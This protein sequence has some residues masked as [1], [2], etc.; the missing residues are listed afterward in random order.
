MSEWSFAFL[1]MWAKLKKK[2]RPRQRCVINVLMGLVV[3]LSALLAANEPVLCVDADTA[4]ADDIV[5][6]VR[7]RMAERPVRVMRCDPSEEPPTWRV[8]ARPTGDDVL[9]LA[10]DGAVTWSQDLDV[11]AMRAAES[12]RLVALHVVEAVRESVSALAVPVEPAAPVAET[13]V[14]PP[15]VLALELQV[16]PVLGADPFAVIGQV[17]LAGKWQREDTSFLG[18]VAARTMD[19]GRRL[20]VAASGFELHLEFA[21]RKRFWQHTDLGL[22][23]RGRAARVTISGSN[24][25]VRNGVRTY[26]DYGAGASALQWLWR[27][28]R[29]AV[30]LVVQATG[31]LRPHWLSVEGQELLRQPRID[32]FLGPVLELQL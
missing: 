17:Q 30:G 25:D 27:G 19:G 18:T 10:I 26:F 28:E 1:P 31:W 20:D 12:S 4:L 14:P 15:S 24:P 2:C 3:V 22:H 6:A 32:V 11:H 13:Q 5:D 16:G 8:T 21:G 29:L 9:S 7:V 23:L